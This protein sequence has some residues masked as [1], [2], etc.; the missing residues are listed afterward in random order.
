MTTCVYKIKYDQSS[1]QL[2]EEYDRLSDYEKEKIADLDT[3]SFF[4]YQDHSDR[5]VCFI[6]STP[7]EVKKY[8]SILLNNLIQHEIIDLTQDILYIIYVVI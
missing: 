3:E 5:Y 7:N 1:F 6:I 2:N 8:S 4:D